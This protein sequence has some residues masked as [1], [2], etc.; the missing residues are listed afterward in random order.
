MRIRN[1]KLQRPSVHPVDER[2]RERE[3]R[4][5]ILSGTPP[6]GPGAPSRERAIA[7]FDA[8]VG[9]LAGHLELI[10]LSETASPGARYRIGAYRF[11]HRHLAILLEGTADPD[12]LAHVLL[13]VV[14]ADLNSALRDQGYDWDR[15]RAG[16]CDLVARALG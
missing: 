9:Y 5:A 14:D 7:F 16:V 13:A 8:Y 15:I 12:H 2:E 11:W 4:G 6:L 10:R 3:L 1:P